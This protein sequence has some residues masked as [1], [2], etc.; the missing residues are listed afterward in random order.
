M[1]KMYGLIDPNRDEA[2]LSVTAMHSSGESI[3]LWINQQ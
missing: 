3:Q 2:W 1:D